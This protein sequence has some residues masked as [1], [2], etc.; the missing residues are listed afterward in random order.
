LPTASP[1]H[2]RKIKMRLSVQLI[3]VVKTARLFKD[4]EYWSMLTLSNGDYMTS[5][6][7]IDWH[8]ANTVKLM[9]SCSLLICLKLRPIWL[10][11][12]LTET[13]IWYMADMVTPSQYSSQK[14]Q[15]ILN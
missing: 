8:E 13:P 12:W 15:L 2:T 9:F 1:T 10:S 14:C 4:N 3:V 7:N 6:A 11:L 5:V